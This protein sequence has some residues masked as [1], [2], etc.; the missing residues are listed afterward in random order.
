M[1]LGGLCPAEYVFGDYFA[2][3][4][5]LDA[6]EKIESQIIDCS[7][8]L[9]VSGEVFRPAEFLETISMCL[10]TLMPRRRFC[11]KS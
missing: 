6:Q 1:Y 2:V 8:V 5:H 10:D 7:S 9:N 4:G 3:P 11:G